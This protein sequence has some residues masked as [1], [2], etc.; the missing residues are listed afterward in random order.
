MILPCKCK[1]EYQDKIY[2]FGLRAHNWARKAN[3]TGAWRYTV[4]Q[5]LH[6]GPAPVEAKAVKK[7]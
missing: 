7:E 5:A 3:T 1:H 6:T 4:C 2:G